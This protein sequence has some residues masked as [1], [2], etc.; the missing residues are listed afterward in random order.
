MNRIVL[1]LSMFTAFFFSV[2]AAQSKTESGV[3]GQLLKIL[4]ERKDAYAKGDKVKWS[5]HIADSCLWVGENVATTA[6]VKDSLARD[7]SS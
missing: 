3:Q 6:D 1:Y 5:A 7:I 2:A 4:H